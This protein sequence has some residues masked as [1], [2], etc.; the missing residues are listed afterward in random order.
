VSPP[1]SLDLEALSGAC[2]PV[3]SHF[4]DY[5]LGRQAFLE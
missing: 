4:G 3:F 5:G 2:S 1:G